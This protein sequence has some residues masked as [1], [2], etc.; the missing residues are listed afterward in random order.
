MLL[1]L[2]MLAAVGV[3]MYGL[4][5][6]TTYA[7]D[8]LHMSAALAFGATVV[9]GLFAAIADPISGLL[10][11]RIGRKPVML[12]AVGLLLVTIVPLFLAMIRLH[13]VMVVYL[14]SAFLAALQAFIS[15]PALITLTESLPRS[16][17]SGV[18]ATLYAIALAAFGGHHSI[19]Y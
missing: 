18:L 2:G 17:R 16:S 4:D 14:A 13:N 10:T 15:A 6:L 3:Y 11:D 7:Q 19:C 9:I 12:A 1:G 8:S 5:Y